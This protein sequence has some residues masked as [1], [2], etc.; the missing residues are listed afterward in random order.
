[1]NELRLE[2]PPRRQTPAPAQPDPHAVA[3][4]LWT[5]GGMLAATAFGLLA[6]SVP[7]AVLVAAV[8]CLVT[9]V[10]IGRRR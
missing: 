3:G 8:W 7:A 9:A 10:L 1:M 2:S 5:A 6:A 4:L